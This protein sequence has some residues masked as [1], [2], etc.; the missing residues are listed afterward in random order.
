M[1]GNVAEFRLIPLFSGRETTFACHVQ[2]VARYMIYDVEYSL[3][4]QGSSVNERRLTADRR[5]DH[6]KQRHPL[7]A[8]DVSVTT[9]VLTRYIRCKL[10]STVFANALA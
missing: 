6:L 10:H 5:V 8:V 4:W 9:R 2:P 1:T 7:K 3:V